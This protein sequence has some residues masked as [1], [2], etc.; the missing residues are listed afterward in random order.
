[1]FRCRYDAFHHSD[2]LYRITATEEEGEHKSEFQ[3]T[4]DTPQL[5]VTRMP[6]ILLYCIYTFIR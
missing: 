4:I 2:I 1:M 3:V 5:A 6:I